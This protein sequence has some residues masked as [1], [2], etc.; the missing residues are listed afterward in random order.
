M[1]F[2][3]FK[4]YDVVQRATTTGLI[5]ATVITGGVFVALAFDIVQKLNSASAKDAKGPS[6]V[7]AEAP[8]IVSRG[9]LDEADDMGAIPPA[10]RLCAGAGTE[11]TLGCPRTSPSLEAPPKGLLLQLRGRRASSRYLRAAGYREETSPRLWRLPDRGSRTPWGVGWQLNEGNTEWGQQGKDELLVKVL[12]RRLGVG[13]EETMVRLD[14]LFLLLPPMQRRVSTMG[15]TRLVALL[16]NLEG[17]VEVLLLLRAALPRT[18]VCEVVCAF[19]DLL[20]WDTAR[21]RRAL[22]ECRAV[23][24]MGQEG[25]ERIAGKVPVVCFHPEQFKRALA[26]IGRL[27]AVEN[28]QAVARVVEN[29]QLLLMGVGGVD[30]LG[31]P[32]VMN[33]SGARQD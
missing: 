1:A 10:E 14:T 11:A 9:A 6:K 30:H 26:E 7:R 4:V 32:D 31:P 27:L 23:P 15:E 20:T 21:V 25:L 17:A 18:D 33:E 16:G 19:P 24:G 12:A 2:S 28:E 8:G 29:P 5:G 22:E 3:R 13:E